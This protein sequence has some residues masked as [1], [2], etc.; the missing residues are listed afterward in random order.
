MTWDIFIGN[1]KISK[2][3]VIEVDCKKDSEG[4]YLFDVY[5]DPIEV[6]TH[7]YVV[8]SHN[9]DLPGIE[10]LKDYRATSNEDLTTILEKKF[11]AVHTLVKLRQI[12]EALPND[13]L[14]KRI[15]NSLI[16]N[17]LDRE[18][19][20]KYWN[21]YTQLTGKIQSELLNLDSTLKLMKTII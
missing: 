12:I 15:K 6:E 16:S 21:T 18:K 4:E 14:S 8:N 2:F 19:K 5:D 11:S 17:A 13:E 9:H 20:I 7:E 10:T 3:D 1:D